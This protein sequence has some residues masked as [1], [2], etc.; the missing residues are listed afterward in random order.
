VR[1][2]PP[3]FAAGAHD[4]VYGTIRDDL[5]L[6]SREAAHMPA[7]LPAK[8]AFTACS[9]VIRVRAKQF[10]DIGQIHDGLLLC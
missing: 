1:D 8:P 9:T 6:G 10:R 5:R 2:I 3:D 7:G 4:F